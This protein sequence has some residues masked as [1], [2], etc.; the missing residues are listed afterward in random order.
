MLLLAEPIIRVIGLHGSNVLKRIMGMI[1]AAVAVKI[2]LGG[3]S[4][5][6]HL[7]GNGY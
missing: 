3:I 2:V 7:P 6:L 1:L 5:W 4:D